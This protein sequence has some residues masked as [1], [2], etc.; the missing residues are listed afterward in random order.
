[1]SEKISNVEIFKYIKEI[2]PKLSDLNYKNIIELSPIY[3]D[4]SSI[5]IDLEN[6]EYLIAILI[7]YLNE[8]SE[9]DKINENIAMLYLNLSVPY[10]DNNE[11]KYEYFSKSFNIYEQLNETEI[12]N[13]YYYFSVFFG[14]SRRFSD[15]NLYNKTV[16]LYSK[17]ENKLPDFEKIHIQNNL[18]SA[19]SNSLSQISIKNYR[20]IKKQIEIDLKPQIN[21]FLAKNGHGKT[22][23]LQ[24]IAIS[25][26][27]ERAEDLPRNFE[28]YISN[29]TKEIEITANWQND[30]KRK[31]FIN[32]VEYKTEEDFV[33][34]KLFLGYGSN[35]FSKYN[36]VK[37]ND[38]EKIISGKEEK[39]FHTKSLFGDYDDNFYDPLE[40]LDKLERYDFDE[41]FSKEQ[42]DEIKEIKELIIGKLNTLIDD[43]EI[44]KDIT[45]YYFYSN[46]NEK[47]L[48]QQLSDGYKSSIFLLTDILIKI[49]TLRKKVIANYDFSD[50]LKPKKEEIKISEV[51]DKV[52]GIIVIDEFDRHLHP[53]WQKVFI[54]KLREILPNIQFILT[55]H[56]AIALAG[57]DRN[58]VNLIDFKDGELSIKKNEVDLWAW[59]YE[60]I[61]SR[62]Y[63]ININFKYT[64]IEL[65][66]DLDKLNKK[67]KKTEEDKAQ[68]LSIEDNL[69]R[70]KD[71]IKYDNETEEL[72]SILQEKQKEL[73]EMINELSVVA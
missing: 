70:L 30:F 57:L 51:Y 56:S 10:I 37:D 19:Y 6:N 42:K 67:K 14:Q 7:N 40:I 59:T 23:I 46:Q 62:F 60:D 12:T 48:T 24:A 36:N 58:Q 45:S 50:F 15:N 32:E 20:L 65:Q 44:K 73:D 47:L 17:Y 8:V 31:V 16:K 55:T 26:I 35:T 5:L 68:I 71:S 66:A 3:V 13:Y 53:S 41:R 22:S 69:K 63:N 49:M 43:F 4:I 11:K 38:I 34:E 18:K 27:P 52:S 2:V 61:L 21:V 72:K 9:E 1:M 54:G 25:V 64:T 39:W 28:N 29:G 33:P